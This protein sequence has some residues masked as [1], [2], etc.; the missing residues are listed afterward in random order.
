MTA[1]HKLVREST[2]HAHLA[3]PVFFYCPRLSTRD[4]TWGRFVGMN[5]Q[6]STKELVSTIEEQREDS[7]TEQQRAEKALRASEERFAKAFRASPMA[8]AISTLEEGR[9]L[10][11]NARFERLT[12]YTVEELVGRTTLDLGLWATP[13]DR[14]RLTRQLATG[15]PVREERVVM[16]T[17]A[18]QARNVLISAELIELDG[19]RCLLI[20]LEDVTEHERTEQSLRDSEQR[21]DAVFQ[22]IPQSIG[23]FRQTERGLV[24]V[25]H[26]RAADAQNP[27]RLADA[28]GKTIQEIWADQPV[29]VEHA[30]RCFQ[31]KSN[32]TLETSYRPIGTDDERQMVFTFVYIPEDRVMLHGTDMT[33]RVRAE[34]ALRLLKEQW[35]QRIAERTAE[36]RRSEAILAQAGKMANLGAWD[37]QFST[38]DQVDPNP[39]TWSDETYRIFGYAP[40]GVRV[41]NDLFFKHVHPDDRERV[42]AAVSQAIATRQPYTVEHRIVRRDGTERIVLEHAD[43][44]FDGQGKPLEIIGAVQDITE[45]KRAEANIRKLN[46]SLEQRAAELEI[47]N[48]ELESFSYS[49]SHDLRTP[50]AAIDGFSHLLEEEYDAN[51]PA[52]GKRY[53][54]LIRTGTRQMDELITSLLRLSRLTR[55]ALKKETVNMNALV[56]QAVET[57]ASEW[58][59]PDVTLDVN[60]LPDAKADP[61]LL[62]QVWVNLIGNAYKFTRKRDHAR[63][64]I[65][66]DRR[67]DAQRV[68]YVRD[69]GVGFDM[70]QADR[71]F[72]VFQRLHGDDEY[73]GTGVGLATV[74]RII[75]RHGGRVWAEAQPNHGATFYFTLGA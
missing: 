30:T 64:E 36:L 24:L 54:N 37:I 46:Q 12:G 21:L 6:K 44:T 31:S 9:I 42:S 55:H 22:G 3:S 33:E 27:G 2:G 73:E 48:G 60:P 49:V 32:L 72:G 23:V 38:S 61:V 53:L 65:G 66:C 63:I 57:M 15:N 19:E 35:E 75:R 41:T 50:L 20:L 39:L 8:M 5:K 16:R 74:Q 14:P 11:A 69:N 1:R 56:T 43:I 47:A 62:K 58:Q 18:G 67:D 4:T 26:N 52:E 10:E 59:R 45:R 51:L 70:R 13:Q 25:S 71:L 68:Y 28:V 34:R 40:H 17:R 29:M 7:T